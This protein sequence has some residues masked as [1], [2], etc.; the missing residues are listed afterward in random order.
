MNARSVAQGVDGAVDAN[1][2]HDGSSWWGS[3][4]CRRRREL[5]RGWYR[6]HS[7][8]REVHLGI[9][10]V[11]GHQVAE[12]GAVVS[13]YRRQ[14]ESD[15]KTLSVGSK[16]DFGREPAARAAKSLVMSPPLAPAAQW[17]ARTIVLSTIC[18]AFCRRLRQD[19]RASDPIARWPSMR[20]N[21]RWTESSSPARPAGHATARQSGQSEDRVHAPAVRADARHAGAR[22]K[23]LER[24]PLLV[25]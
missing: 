20:R 5:R 3:L 16:V 21:C 18:S 11:L 4:A 15:R 10:V 17:C 1:A 12:R 2:G 7:P 9:G 23:W 24:R 25:G 13:L 22:D 19:R 6:C 8:G 14:Q